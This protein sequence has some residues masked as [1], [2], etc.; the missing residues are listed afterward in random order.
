MN[1][2]LLATALL[3]GLFAAAQ[4][5]CEAEDARFGEADSDSDGDSASDTDSAS[6]SDS[7]SDSDTGE[8]DCTPGEIFCFEGDV[9]ECTGTDNEMELVEECPS[10]LICMNGMCI[11]DDACGYAVANK[12]NIGCEYWAIDMD[13]STADQPYAIAVSNLDAATAMVTVEQRTATGYTPI[14]SASVESKQV[15]VFMLGDTTTSGS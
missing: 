10:P 11:D 15:H 14:E 7:D 8:E 6:D 12:S 5:A 9:Y 4:L 2:R 1:Y 3:A 13:N